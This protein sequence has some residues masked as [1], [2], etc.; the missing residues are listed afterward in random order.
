MHF[1]ITTLEDFQLSAELAHECFA[2]PVSLEEYLDFHAHDLTFDNYEIVAGNW[3]EYNICINLHSLQEAITE[4]FDDIEVT[5]DQI[6]TLRTRYHEAFLYSNDTENIHRLELQIVKT[7][8]P[9]TSTQVWGFEFNTPI[10]ESDR[11]AFDQRIDNAP[12]ID[13]WLSKQGILNDAS[14]VSLFSRRVYDP[15]E[16]ESLYSIFQNGPIA[17]TFATITAEEGDYVGVGFATMYIRSNATTPVVLDG[18]PQLFKYL[19]GDHEFTVRVIKHE[20]ESLPI[21]EQGNS[22]HVEKLFKLYFEYLEPIEEPM[23]EY[24]AIRYI[25]EH[26]Y[27][28]L[29]TISD[30]ESIDEFYDTYCSIYI[31]NANKDVGITVSEP[32]H[33]LSVFEFIYV[34]KL[35]RFHLEA[36]EIFKQNGHYE[37]YTY[38]VDYDI[39]A[40]TVDLD[41]SNHTAIFHK[42]ND[43]IE[44]FELKVN[45]ELNL[46]RGNRWSPEELASFLVRHG[47]FAV[48]TTEQVSGYDGDMWTNCHACYDK[49]QTLLFVIETVSRKGYCEE[50]S[51]LMNTLNQALGGGRHL[52]SVNEFNIT[53][54]H[55]INTNTTHLKP[56]GFLSQ[57]VATY[58]I[59]LLQIKNPS[60]QSLLSIDEVDQGL[61]NQL[62]KHSRCEHTLLMCS[63]IIMPIQKFDLIGHMI[64]QLGIK[65]TAD[66]E[67]IKQLSQSVQRHLGAR[68]DSESM[69][70]MPVI[71]DIP[72]G[73]LTNFVFEFNM[74]RGGVFN[75]R[76]PLE[77]FVPETIIKDFTNSIG[78]GT[79]LDL[80]L[81]HPEFIEEMSIF[82]TPRES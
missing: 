44:G 55:D 64:E 16:V 18:E 42:I 59:A 60:I 77:S 56:E 65:T 35:S 20:V 70:L 54:T 50:Y 26:Q 32:C 49:N 67:K 28:T 7:A 19:H 47:T 75:E 25:A 76:S 61:I 8:N 27:N 53:Y 43:E 29:T 45:G 1:F 33:G 82:S 72:K 69:I 79:L 34:E 71:T 14:K 4:H 21:L 11:E 63:P 78:G 12:T 9:Y 2:V 68:F 23:D 80:H 66:T 13:K 17:S 38:T 39:E 51:A 22:E 36:I 15:Y 31:D 58:L 81:L 46:A 10:S 74:I 62:T 5:T 24:Q 57:T 3:N 52:K 30:G 48:S 6:E 40:Y 37:N 73:E 41:D